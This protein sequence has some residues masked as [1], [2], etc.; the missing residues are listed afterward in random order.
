MSPILTLLTTLL[1]A[2]SGALFAQ[3]VP[4]SLSTDMIQ[5]LRT[6]SAQRCDAFFR[7]QSGQPFAP[8][9]IIK[10]WNH[11][12]DF[13]RHYVQSA[14]LFA[15]RALYLNERIEEANKA[16]SEMCQYHLDRP[17]TL[18]E[19][20][21]FP[22]ALRYLAQLAQFYGPDGT[23][24]KGRL[25]PETYRVMLATMWEWAKVK[26]KMTACVVDDSR[27]WTVTDS[28]NHHANHFAS[29]W[30]VTAFLARVPEYC[31][32]KFDDGHSAKEHSAAWTVYLREYLSERGRKGMT[33]EI[34]SPSYASATLGAVYWLYELS[35]DPVLKQRASAYITLYWALWAQQQIDGV[36]GG[37][38]ARCYPSSAK[39][40]ESFVG[41]AAWYALGIGSPEFVHLGMLP[42]V[43]SSWK[44][45][46]VVMDLA[47]DVKGRGSYEVMERRPGI[48][49]PG[50]ER[51]KGVSF[52]A[53]EGGGLVRYSYCTPEF[54]MGSLLCAARPASD[55]TTMSSQN[56]WH[57]V[58][59]RGAMNAR[60]YPYCETD[61]SSYN[62]QWAVQHKGTLIAQKLKTSQHADGL[63]VWISEAELT[64]PVKES[65]W[66]FTEA[67]GA[68]AA[69]RVISG[70]TK[71]IPPAAPAKK[72]KPLSKAGTSDDGDT[73][74]SGANGWLLQCSDEWSP[75]IIE[76]ATKA[77]Y[78]TREAFQKAIQAR[79]VKSEGGLLTYTGLSG[80]RFIFFTDQTELPR[81][82]DE[83]V[84]LAPTRVYDSP[85]VQSDWKSGVVTIQK[86]DRKLVL[87]FNE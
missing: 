51:K 66:F 11:R 67:A 70:D 87:N 53:P 9:P 84:N 24:G 64:A 49:K 40:G 46:D 23:R 82:N 47:L 39:N 60:I 83:P 43:T 14:L 12:G 54:I 48:A 7:K 73:I 6:E 72:K 75:V 36:A 22:G 31:D 68:W 13:T 55:W 8:E 77:D 80:D 19:I 81:V 42:F 85:F 76:A 38:K 4:G 16:L 20:H 86:G 59:F 26:S 63:R 34:E 35:D 3:N 45:P 44:V 74:D 1:L 78:P 65:D 56:R 33:V 29:C 28:E 15:S 21:S 50:V 52:A 79:E 30:A 27:T 25:S 61:H 41:R 37:A 2:T 57:G 32:R 69:V 18:L 58:I 17:Q 5:Q 10:D 62:Q 71:L